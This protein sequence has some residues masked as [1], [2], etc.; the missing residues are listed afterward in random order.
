MQREK[1]P[2]LTI[3]AEFFKVQNLRFFKVVNPCFWSKNA[4]FSLLRFA[5]NKTRNNAFWVCKEKLR[6]FFDL[7]KKQNSSESKKSLF[8][9]G[10]KPCFWPKNANFFSLFKFDQNKPRNNAFWLCREEKKLFNLTKQ[11]FSKSKKSHFFSKGVNLC[12]CPKNAN[13]FS[14]FKFDQNKPRN[15]A[16]WLCREKRNLFYFKKQIFLKSRK[17]HFSKVLTHAFNQKMTIFSLFTIDK[18]KTRNIAWWLRRE[19]RNLF[20]L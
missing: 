10:V 6:N 14:L 20:L 18:K 9:Q 1:I 19:K 12:F 16:Y 13:F 2:V 5:Q 8:F 17:S 15:N 11:N 4:F 7:K 3:K